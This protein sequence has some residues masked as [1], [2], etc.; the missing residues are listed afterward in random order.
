MKDD[1]LK[2]V[3]V[4]VSTVTLSWPPYTPAPSIT[5]G[6]RSLG[7]TVASYDVEMT[8]N[9]HGWTVVDNVSSRTPKDIGVHVSNIVFCKNSNFY[10]KSTTTNA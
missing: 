8:T 2:I 9:D 1:A 10:F 5:G 7:V 6:S 3:M 4:T